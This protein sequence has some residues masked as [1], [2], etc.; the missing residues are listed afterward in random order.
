MKPNSRLASLLLRIG[1]AAVFLYAAGS[2][3]LNPD[4]WI[5]FLPQFLVRILPERVLLPGFSFYQIILS[6]WL[7][8]GR[9]VKYS[10]TLSALTL[11]LIIVLN[12]GAL[13]VVFRDIAILFASLALIFI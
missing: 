13:D 7:L 10:A 3:Y 5:G 4:A 11:F 8:W 6:L 9:G 1:L 12:F 2:T